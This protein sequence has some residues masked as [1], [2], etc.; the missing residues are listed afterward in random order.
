MEHS[1]K[2]PDLFFH[3][4]Q[5]RRAQ[6][7][8]AY[9]DQIKRENEN[10][11]FHFDVKIDLDDA[12]KNPEFKFQKN[13]AFHPL[14]YLKQFYDLA[15]E[16]SRRSG[17]PIFQLLWMDKNFKYLPREFHYLRDLSFISYSFLFYKSS[18]TLKLE[19]ESDVLFQASGNACVKTPGITVRYEKIP[20]LM[21][22]VLRGK[23]E[24]FTHKSENEVHCILSN[25]SPDKTLNQ[26]RGILRIFQQPN[27]QISKGI[28]FLRKNFDTV[29]SESYVKDDWIRI[30][31]VIF[32]REDYLMQC[33]KD[34]PSLINEVRLLA[35]DLLLFHRQKI[36]SKNNTELIYLFIQIETL[37]GTKFPE[38]DSYFN[39]LRSFAYEF[40]NESKDQFILLILL[41]SLKTPQ[42]TH[43]WLEW[44]TAALNWSST[45][46]SSYSHIFVDIQRAMVKLLPQ[47]LSEI[48]KMNLQL[49]EIRDYAEK[50]TGQ[51]VQSISWHQPGKI[52]K[53]N[54]LLVNI[55]TL[56][57]TDIDGLPL[58]CKSN[59]HLLGDHHNLNLTIGRWVT[60][61]YWKSGDGNLE[62]YKEVGAGEA[63]FRKFKSPHGFLKYKLVALSWF[64]TENEKILLEFINFLRNFRKYA[65]AW[66]CVE[67]G[68]TPHIYI[69]SRME[70]DELIAYLPI[71]NG[72]YEIF[73]TDREGNVLP[74][75]WCKLTDEGKKALNLG[76]EYQIWLEKYSGEPH[77]LIIP[78]LA[79]EFNCETINGVTIFK[80]SEDSNFHLC[81]G[82]YF[83]DFK[84]F[85]DHVILKSRFHGS[86]L[87]M[88]DDIGFSKPLEGSYGYKAIQYQ[89]DPTDNS[90]Y[91]PSSS[92]NWYLAYKYLMSKN[93]KMGFRILP[94]LSSL[95]SYTKELNIIDRLAKDFKDH[96]PEGISFALRLALKLFDNMNLPRTLSSKDS[97][98]NKRKEALFG[99]ILKCYKSYVSFLSNYSLNSVPIELRLSRDLEQRLVNNLRN[100][101][102]EKQEWNLF[103]EN[104][105]FLLKNP[106]QTTTLS[107]PPIYMTYPL[108]TLKT[109]YTYFD[110]TMLFDIH[111]KYPQTEIP[112]GKVRFTLEDFNKH[113]SYIYDLIIS[114]KGIKTHSADLLLFNLSRSKEDSLIY[115]QT[116]AI[117]F[118]I[119]TYTD[120]FVGFSF[121]SC[122][123]KKQL[124]EVFKLIIQK[125]KQSQ[126]M[127]T[128]AVSSFLSATASYFPYLH[129]NFNFT[130]S[131]NLPKPP[132]EIPW[133]FAESD[134][135]ILLKLKKG[136]ALSLF[137]KHIKSEK[138][139]YKPLP[140]ELK[141]ETAMEQYFYSKLEKGRKKLEKHPKYTFGLKENGQFNDFLVDLHDWINL[142][143]LEL[144]NDFQVL[145]SRSNQFYS[146]RIGKISR[147]QLHSDTLLGLKR[148]SNQ[149]FES[150]LSNTFIEALKSRDLRK[151]IRENSAI[152]VDEAKKLLILSVKYL[153]LSIL[154]NKIESAIEDLKNG[155]VKEEDFVKT[156]AP[157]LNWNCKIDLIHE[158]EVVV[159][160]SNFKQLPR[161]EQSDILDWV[162]SSPLDKD[163][164]SS[165][166][167]EFGAGGGKSTFIK[168]ILLAREQYKG[169][170]TVGVSP[171][172]LL[173]LDSEKQRENMMLGFLHRVSLL[174]LNLT[175]SYSYEELYSYYIHM[176]KVERDKIHLSIS[177]KNQYA[178][179]LHLK[180]ARTRGDVKSVEYLSFIVN[181]LKNKGCALWDESR[182]T[183]SPRSQAKVAFGV[184]EPIDISER[185]LILS[186]YKRIYEIALDHDVGNFLGTL[187]LNR[188]EIAKP[189]LSEAWLKIPS[190]NEKEVLNFWLDPKAE[191]PKYILDLYAVDKV[192]ANGHALLKEFLTSYLPLLG[193]L[194]LGDDHKR[195]TV[196][197]EDFD[198]PLMCKSPTEA[199]FDDAYLSTGVT[200]QGHLQRGLEFDQVKK[201]ITE[202]K[203]KILQDLH[204]GIPLESSEVFSQWNKW[205]NSEANPI[206]FNMDEL[207]EHH[208]WTTALKKNP[209]AIFWYLD[210]VVLKQ[211]L[212]PKQY[213]VVTP[214][215]LLNSYKKNILFSAYT[216][217]PELYPIDPTH[218]NIK[219]VKKDHGFLFRIIQ[220]LLEPVNSR[221]H[222]VTD[223]DPTPLFTQLYQGCPNLFNDLRTIL[224]VG[225]AL[226]SKDNRQIAR[227]FM[228][229]SN[230]NGLNYKACV[231]FP[232]IANKQLP[233]AAYMVINP[234]ADPLP[235]EGEI[236]AFCKQHKIDWVKDKVMVYV[237]RDYVAGSNVLHPKGARGLVLTGDKLDLGFLVQGPPRLRDIFDSQMIDWCVTN[238]HRIESD[239]KMKISP[240]AII[241]WSFSREGVDIAP[242]ILM[243]A[244]Q[245]I[246][247][248]VESIAES[249]MEAAVNDSAKQIE[250][251]KT[252]EKGY[253]QTDDKDAFQKFI[254]P[255]RSTPTATQLMKYAEATYAM[256]NY[257]QKDLKKSKI[258]KPIQNLIGVISALIPETT[259]RSDKLVPGFT[260]MHCIKVQKALNIEHKNSQDYL[261]AVPQ[262]PLSRNFHPYSNDFLHALSKESLAA[263][264]LFKT[265]ILEPTLYYTNN[266]IRTASD[267]RIPLAEKYLKPCQFLL[268]LWENDK[269]FKVFALSDTEASQ[270]K[271]WLLEEPKTNFRRKVILINTSGYVEQNGKGSY[272]L[273]QEEIS[274][275]LLSKQFSDIIVDAN[276][277]HGTIYAPKQ[278]KAKYEGKEGFAELFNRLRLAAP[279]P[280][281]FD[282]K[283]ILSLIP[284]LS[285]K[286]GNGEKNNST[287]QKSILNKFFNWN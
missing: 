44:V 256:F 275:L 76:S 157:L 141:A 124:N 152:S 179:L 10:T 147:E 92:A 153:F 165:I 201:L 237:S 252:Y 172:A 8:K 181:E 212:V 139:V 120:L 133:I 202:V 39:F 62:F 192:A 187:P 130:M 185:N 49:P 175:E 277:I 248:Y 177:P 196:E 207:T 183:L 261:E 13:H 176:D 116:I 144:Q 41:Y 83:Q 278:F 169:H 99:F 195:S 136:P 47:W 215:H 52:I 63:I 108:D 271:I 51:K 171:P 251:A 57:I 270:I 239:T 226:S 219:T 189:F 166:L 238:Q 58:N 264:V 35:R 199:Q 163:K 272:G 161:A 17:T 6:L 186:I 188:E 119:R 283:G 143:K 134:L 236:P 77:K 50:W 12:L 164:C 160:F 223:T 56:S 98:E 90:L 11:L 263:R 53:A 88:K 146:D 33:L 279:L 109:K 253:I 267:G 142:T 78:E 29:F 216:S 246:S 274:N 243:R 225:A 82:S 125:A 66:I 132:P 100:H 131:I 73:K 48:E 71:T 107:V 222:I 23:N 204:H 30:F 155:E 36:I 260:Y 102:K 145:K 113:F 213:L 209:E 203:S 273:S 3:P 284:L 7:I 280:E 129:G 84:S 198:V 38:E 234:E 91:N 174:S 112:K 258:Y 178:L 46:D 211:I 240:L 127:I 94:H 96:S 67:E 208:P 104:R 123:D 20:K 149:D 182:I 118:F 231:F 230:Q 18:T 235:I 205:I 285:S 79:L 75:Q 241:K 197:G 168:S 217:L 60:K 89:V 268:F 59:A 255:I 70:R 37:I 95:Q 15:A 115:K 170:I 64:P 151:I 180:L 5:Y 2:F 126:G 121:K 282:E 81:V 22:H 245:Q 105:Y 227:T 106:E 54:N 269:T 28:H 194:K 128:K 286:S 138:V 210:N 97:I 14:N 257:K 4:E 93:Y 87:L 74:Y 242:E 148:T 111:L 214:C 65:G 101:F 80:W 1:S 167:F 85:K 43:E 68:V 32:F 173:P 224:D 287:Q 191:P 42:N 21:R 86:Y 162:F 25:S 158:T 259:S 45:Q 9:S 117:L 69:S 156:V 72:K 276:F 55:E 221:M 26:Y 281:M 228:Q 103:L 232:G 218:E 220:R 114:A 266:A 135:S 122:T 40:K 16:D 247:F 229:F 159:M 24:F 140:A 137:E 27:L 110:D 31:T 190:G 254:Q 233:A 249:E 250:I 34:N 262:A 154:T 200:I 150:T 193:S 206:A 244:Y 265:D 61:T 184:S 19:S